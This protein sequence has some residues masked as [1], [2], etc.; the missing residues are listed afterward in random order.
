MN[1]DKT[2]RLENDHLQ[3]SVDGR[4][5]EY[6]ILHKPS[7][8]LWC[9]PAGRL[10]A[11]T[12]KPNDDRAQSGFDRDQARLLVNRFTQIACDQSAIVACYTPAG[13]ATAETDHQ[14]EFRLT[15]CAEAQ[16][17]MSYRVLRDDPAW[18][19]HSVDMIDDALAICGGGDYAI[20]PVYQGE[21]IA[22][23]RVFSYL[24]KDREP[25]IRTSDVA[26]TYT[27][28][29]QWNMA[30]L[31]LVMRGSAAVVSWDD[32][33]VEAGLCG[34]QIAAAVGAPQVMHSVDQDIKAKTDD[35]GRQITAT[36]SLCRAARSLRIDFL[37]HA[38]YVQIAEHYRRTARRRGLFVT[39]KQKVSRSSEVA[40]NI[41][42]LRFTVAPL[43]GRSA[44]A[45][46]LDT[47]GAG[48]TR[49]DYT[50]TQVAEIAEHL[51]HQLGVDKAQLI[52]K[53][54]TRRGY[55]MDY[56]DVFPA[57]EVCGG[58]DA[59]ADA[60]RRVQALGWLFGVHDN[61]VI[62]FKEAAS[63]DPAD[64]LMRADGT[65]VEGNIGVPRWRNY[66]CSPACMIK[67]AA[68]NY[69]R[70]K[71]LLDLNFIYTDQIAAL[72][73]V[74]D[75]SPDHPLTRR[76]AIEAYQSLIEF[77]RSY[78]PVIVSELMDEW[79][80]PLFDAMGSFMGNAHDYARPI[81]LF[82]LIY[83]QCCN[84]DAWA[85]GSLAAQTII[86]CIAIGRMPYLPFAQHNYLT[87]GLEV[88]P[89]PGVYN[90]AGG[91]LRWDCSWLQG[92]HAD[93][94]FFRGD[95]GWGQLH[96]ADSNWYDRFVRNVYEATS[97]L[98]E[99]TA[100]E[101]MTDH[102]FLADDRP[103]EKVTFANGVSI[104]SNR[105]DADFQYESTL[106]PPMGFLAAGPQ[107]LAFYAKE[108]GG[109]AYPDGALYVA[110]ALDEK[111]VEQSNRLRIYHGFGRGP[112]RIGDGLAEVADEQIVS[113]R[114]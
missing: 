36:V 87:D 70:Y 62:L 66:C 55:D 112:I 98:N 79:A 16:I 32:P 97:P 30:M 49:C 76:Q 18:R 20:A 110:R 78:V 35:T 67:S 8:D 28:I 64:A 105:S 88:D 68:R 85:W 23:G 96:C 19:I 34:R 42:A 104:V 99:M 60:S 26:G 63:T 109:V 27:G 38:G 41:G 81:P 43:W 71:E 106:L 25:A 10:G 75:F 114:P 37:H 53:A 111:P 9:G 101:A 51:K 31:A 102:Q 59:L 13:I 86:N 24:P 5:G 80:V 7:G 54:W 48:Q 61:S 50:F 33:D 108:H 12:L 77:K 107:L 90:P 91:R 11:I 65:R 14:I 2:H 74:E 57:A 95:H 3:L 100:H 94:P 72:P 93:N 84:F 15:L 46:W 44:G 21:K 17:E 89:E 82:E 29:G 56:P 113:A 73:I 58:N 52:V 92:Y 103:V 39:L 22:V 47:I 69:P 40:K 6:S 1:Q 4:T 45:G 83:R